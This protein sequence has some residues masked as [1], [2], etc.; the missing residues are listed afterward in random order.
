MIGGFGHI[1]VITQN[2]PWYYL[3][4]G[5]IKLVLIMVLHLVLHMDMLKAVFVPVP[6][7]FPYI[8]SMVGLMVV[9]FCHLGVVIIYS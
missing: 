9:N 2:P 8:N 3:V 6:L 1:I 4:R 7:I 5:I